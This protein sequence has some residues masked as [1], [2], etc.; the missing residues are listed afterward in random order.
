VQI[1]QRRAIV[2]PGDFVD[3]AFEQAPEAFGLAM[4]A[5]V[6]ASH[7]CARCLS[8]ARGTSLRFSRRHTAA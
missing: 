2:E 8:I 7:A 3:Y 1:T 6:F 4:N 5:A